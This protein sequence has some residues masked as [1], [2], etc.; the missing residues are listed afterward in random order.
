M[1]QI[2]WVLIRKRAVQILLPL[3]PLLAWEVGHLVLGFLKKELQ[4]GL[5]LFQVSSLSIARC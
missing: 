3:R 2:I 4:L 1:L 5:S